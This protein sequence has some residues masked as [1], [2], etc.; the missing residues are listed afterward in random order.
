MTAAA[1]ADKLFG[2]AG[3][4][5]LNGGKGNDTLTGGAGAD[6]FVYATGDGNDVITDYTTQDKLRITGSYSTLTS[7]NDVVVKVGSGRMTLK[8]AKGVKLNIIKASKYEE[9]WFTEDDI[10]FTTS[11]VS[12]ILKSDN[13][14]SNDYKLNTELKLNQN[15]DITSLSYSY[16]QKK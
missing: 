6:V 12:S 11:E 13:L 10:N 9:R 4:D 8:N 2:D 3:N 7:G 1:G 5:T 15:A 14:I 16:S